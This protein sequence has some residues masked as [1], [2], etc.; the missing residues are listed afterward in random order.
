MS[1][2]LPVVRGEAQLCPEGREA[3]G[4]AIAIGFVSYLVVSPWLRC[5]GVGRQL[6]E[7]GKTVL[8]SGTAGWRAGAI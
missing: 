1:R 8:R 6:F 2:S 3:T 4:A 5:R 7:E